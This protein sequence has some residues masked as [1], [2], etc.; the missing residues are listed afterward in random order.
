MLGEPGLNDLGLVSPVSW[1]SNRND[2]QNVTL[3]TDSDNCER[4]LPL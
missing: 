2:Q 1:L 3:P 4:V